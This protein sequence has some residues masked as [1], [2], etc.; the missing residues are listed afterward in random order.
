MNQA[1]RMRQFATQIINPYQGKS[2]W[3]GIPGFSYEITSIDWYK[4]CI[5]GFLLVVA[6]IIVVF[7]GAILCL[8][9]MIVSQ[10][11]SLFS[12]YI[13]KRPI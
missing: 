3:S 1:E 13:L 4:Q 7:I 12:R 9:V 11:I 5:I 10:I 8:P 2:P 6:A